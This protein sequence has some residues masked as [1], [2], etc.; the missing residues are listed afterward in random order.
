MIDEG[1]QYFLSRPR[2]FGKS[3]LIDTIAE[4]FAGNEPLFRGLLIHPG[5]DW[6]TRYPGSRICGP[7]RRSCRPSTSIIWPPR[8]GCGRRAI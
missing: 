4:L 5:W 2:R 8:R 7:T 3:L 1:G 6:T